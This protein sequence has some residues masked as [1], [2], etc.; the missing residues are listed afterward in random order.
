M[1]AHESQLWV[2]R[3]CGGSIALVAS[4][5]GREQSSAELFAIGSGSL[6]RLMDA[7]GTAGAAGLQGTAEVREA[8]RGGPAGVF[9]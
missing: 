9:C 3:N 5:G 2:N 7:P 6:P 8:P 1:R 4:V